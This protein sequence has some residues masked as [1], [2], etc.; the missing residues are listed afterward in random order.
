MLELEILACFLLMMFI[1]TKNS[2]KKDSGKSE[3]KEKASS[4][5]PGKE[6]KI[7]ESKLSDLEGRIENQEKTI[8]KLL[9]SCE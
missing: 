2:S 7:I 4:I 8:K 3:N 5:D 9:T 6:L 1:K